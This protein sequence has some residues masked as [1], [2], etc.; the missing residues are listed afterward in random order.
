MGFTIEESFSH[1]DGRHIRASRERHDGRESCRGC[2]AANDCA[3][4]ITSEAGCGWQIYTDIVNG[5]I[6]AEYRLS[7]LSNLGPA[8]L[9]PLAS[10]IK[11]AWGE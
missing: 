2:P 6:A 1:R 10:L 7:P 11:E 5:L 8:D 3:K 4:R 9:P